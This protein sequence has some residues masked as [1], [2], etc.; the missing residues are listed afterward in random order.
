M[1]LVVWIGWSIFT[2]H[3]WVYVDNNFR[4]ECAEAN[5][6]HTCSGRCLPTQQARL[7]DLWDDI[8]LPYE[9]NKQQFGERLCIIGFDIDP[10]AMT[11]SIPIDARDRFLTL[12]TDFIH[13]TSD[14]RHS[15][16]EFQSLAGYANWIFNIY[17]SWET[18][19]HAQSTI[20]LQAKPMCQLVSILTKLLQ[21]NFTG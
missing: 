11:V 21:M 2:L 14:R 20:K 7:L 1:C 13:I 10:N 8:G 6:F 5:V 18:W 12:V 16:Q 9:N 4:F 3:Y 17:P 15:L 19:P